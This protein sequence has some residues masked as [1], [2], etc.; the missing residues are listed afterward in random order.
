M[1]ERSDRIRI[2]CR[3]LQLHIQ[4][5]LEWLAVAA[6]A[7]YT[8]PAVAPKTACMPRV[9]APAVSSDFVMYRTNHYQHATPVFYHTL[10]KTSFIHSFIHSFYVLQRRKID[11]AACLGRPL[12]GA[13]TVGC[14]YPGRPKTSSSANLFADLVALPAT[15]RPSLA[16]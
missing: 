10:I 15:T 3:I 11:H 7:A 2:G 9:T 1:V 6:N 8:N 4:R 14:G 5:Q 13:R 16:V 12:P